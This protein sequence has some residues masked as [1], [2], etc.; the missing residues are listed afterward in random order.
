M[1]EFNR[2][3]VADRRAVEPVCPS[4]Q[5]LPEK[6]LLAS[7]C[8]HSGEQKD[9]RRA[10]RRA[11]SLTGKELRRRGGSSNRRFRGFDAGGVVGGKPSL[12]Q[13]VR[14]SKQ[15]RCQVG[16]FVAGAVHGVDLQF[17]R[18]DAVA[19]FGLLACECFLIDLVIDPQF[20]QPILLIG[21]QR[22]SAGQLAPLGAGV[23]L[24]VAGSARRERP[25]INRDRPGLRPACGRTG[26]TSGGRVR[27]RS[28]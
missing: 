10:H 8:L 11:F 28:P 4:P 22:Q 2:L 20:H 12:S 16:S 5:A 15:F 6:V 3:E 1:G 27:P 21:Q 25:G 26:P 19:A 17:D 13:C 9:L 23:R 24:G 14:K 7:S 18:G